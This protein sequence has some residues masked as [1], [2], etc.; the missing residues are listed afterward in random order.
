MGGKPG[1][2][3]MPGAGGRRQ[4]WPRRAPVTHHR[5]GEPPLY[6][7]PP[8]SGWTQVEIYATFMKL[9]GEME[10]VRPDRLSDSVNHAEH[11][12]SLRDT[13]AEPL[14][15]NYPVLSRVEP[16]TTIAKS[17]VILLCPLE[18]PAEEA[19]AVARRPKLAHQAAFNTV[20]FSLVGDIH[21]DPGQ[22]LRDHL[23]R[24]PG[25][26]L[27]LTNVSALWVTAL[28]SETHAVQRSFALL[29]PAAILSFSDR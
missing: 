1:G 8:M 12:L 22:S 17:A 6:H 7:R 19:P 13:R 18:E 3:G 9:T 28:S 21:L 23:E 16:R 25:D 2:P 11:Y 5:S 27:P 20:A 29:N 10:V 15:V 4:K 14:S 26:F 24:H